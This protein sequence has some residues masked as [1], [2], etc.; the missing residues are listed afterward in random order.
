MSLIK[1]SSMVF[2]LPTSAS[3]NHDD[4]NTEPTDNAHAEYA[5]MCAEPIFVDGGGGVGFD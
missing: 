5:A 2:I 1:S 4:R 3:M